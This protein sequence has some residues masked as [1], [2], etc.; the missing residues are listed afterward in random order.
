VDFNKLIARAKA[1][2][3]SPKSEWPVIAGEPA[4]AG[5]LYRNYILAL[6]AIP[7]VFTFLQ[8][9]V[10]GT[11]VW[12][13]GKVRLG[14]GAGLSSAIVSYV[15]TLVGVYVMALIVEA[16][17]PTFGGQKDRVQALKAVAYASTA[18]WVSGI[19][20]ILPG[21]GWLILLAGG[22]YSIYLLYLG[23]PHTMKSP[24]QKSLG[25]TV[26]TFIAAFVLYLIIGAI[27]ASLVGGS[28]MRGAS[29]FGGGS[30]LNIDK[31]SPLG[32]MEQWGKNV[33]EASKRLEAAQQSGD[34]AA[35]ADA[36]AQM[37]GAALGGASTTKVESLTPERLK[38]FLPESLAGL[39]RSSLSAE[40]NQAMGMQRSEARATYSSG[41]GR[42]GNV[43]I[44]DTGSA[45]GLLAL[46]GWSG[47][48]SE[49]ESDSGYE[50]TYRQDGRLVH[51]QW[52][53][54]GSYGE[55]S[56]VL[57]DRFTVKVDGEADGIGDLKA[58]LGQLDLRGLEAL[59]DDGV[60]AN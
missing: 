15:L 45:K 55:Y 58:T 48:E 51:E 38:S 12:M 6:A 50:K 18:S 10:I 42:S 14:V 25:Y 40:R 7:A 35:Q 17:A 27:A 2:L 3:L 4:S 20:A 16:L 34:Q 53:R 57:G 36:L 11:N 5:D 13:A 44:T 1:I 23:L 22:C 43:E 37:M 21:L 9:S 24:A 30:D 32:Q 26:V 54:A 8:M 31:D 39:Q 19:G 47:M 59:K 46:A 56:V 41:A 29:T 60:A 52:D 28:Y 33:E 49:Q